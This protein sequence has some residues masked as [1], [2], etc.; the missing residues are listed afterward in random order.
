MYIDGL[1]IE[2]IVL[3]FLYLLTFRDAWNHLNDNKDMW[4]YL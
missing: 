4:L 2:T 3:L 1:T